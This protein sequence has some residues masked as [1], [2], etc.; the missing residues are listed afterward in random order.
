[1]SYRNLSKGLEF[2]EKYWPRTKHVINKVYVWQPGTQFK[3]K[4]PRYPYHTFI[5]NMEFQLKTNPDMYNFTVKYTGILRPKTREIYM[6]HKSAEKRLRVLEQLD[7]KQIESE[8]YKNIFKD[9][10]YTLSTAIDHMYI[11]NKDCVRLYEI[12]MGIE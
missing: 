11:L 9:S 5:D 7:L 10:S 2:V 1:M 3:L 6:A 12:Y 8:E 4:E